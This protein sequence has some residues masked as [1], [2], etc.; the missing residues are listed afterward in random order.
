MT[1]AYADLDSALLSLRRLWAHS[2]TFHDPDLGPVDLSTVLICREL[3][4]SA[5]AE[6]SVTD[7]AS[8]LDVA[9]STAS[10]LV[11]HAEQSGAV[12][13]VPS[14]H[15]SRRT[16]VTLTPAGQQLHDVA[17]RFR[18]SYLHALLTDWQSAELD[19]FARLLTRF[20]ES[21][22]AHTPG[23]TP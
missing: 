2:G 14:A 16:A 21:V 10:R 12:Q 6:V 20:A 3:A 19:T 13:R 15:D 18:V 11:D 22:K 1:S 23:G 17:T 4:A 9:P 5:T 8:G 7:I